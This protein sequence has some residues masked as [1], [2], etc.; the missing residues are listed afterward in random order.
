MA[1]AA[2]AVVTG[3]A[4]ASGGAAAGGQSPSANTTSTSTQGSAPASTDWTSG[5]TDEMRGYVQNKGFKAPQD[6]VE[7]YR[8]FEKLHGVPQDRILKLPENL[9]TQRGKLSGSALVLRKKPRIT[10]S[11]FQK[12]T[13]TK[14]LL[15]GFGILQR[16]SISRT[17]RSRALSAGGMSVR[18]E[19]LKPRPRCIKPC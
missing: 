9:D 3:E 19:T 14:S 1:D 6:V 17:N 15:K 4:G 10:I 2:A 12:S 5:L 13:A 16:N 11:I 7:S 18:P 8:N